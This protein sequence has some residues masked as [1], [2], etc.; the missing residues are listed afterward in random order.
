MTNA[1]RT[2][3][4]AVVA[5]SVMAGATV[6]AVPAQPARAGTGVP[7]RAASIK[8]VPLPMGFPA[9]LNNAGEII[10]TG[11][12][13]MGLVWRDGTS[14][15]I[16]SLGGGYS[17]PT[18]INRR[19]QVVGSSSTAGGGGHAFL[20]HRGIMT[21]LGTLGGPDSSA[22]AVNDHGEVVGISTTADGS[23]AYFLW[24]RGVMTRIPV[25]GEVPVTAGLIFINNH[26]QVLG[27]YL[28][29]A[30]EPP[31][32]TSGLWLWDN[33]V[34]TDLGT[35]GAFGARPFGLNDRGQVLGLQV[36][37][38]FEESV[39]LRHRGVTTA[40]GRADLISGLGRLA[41]NERGQVGFTGPPP[42][43]G[44]D[45]AY[46]WR[47]GV[48]TDLGDLGGGSAAL[49]DLN[50]RGEASG[51]SNDGTVGNRAYVWRRG[52][53][54]ALDPLDG[55]QNSQGQSINDGGLVIGIS[56]TDFDVRG[57]VWNTR[58]PR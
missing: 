41:L 26:G 11:E 33:G 9:G 7:V 47:D 55:H 5:V 8:G 29:T 12:D 51:T 54:T 57:M 18:D 17:A 40:V 24:R 14:T 1:T 53:M 44:G 27:E 43:G 58:P 32:Q 46:L 10:G 49:F 2:R 6:A 39:F 22:A 21:D 15:H 16:G 4:L 50:E 25:P 35:L 34:L 20:W 3:A 23:P 13:G 37:P 42:G 36:S 56:A 19:G 52:V 31:R 30:G 48:R 38:D 28:F 45:R